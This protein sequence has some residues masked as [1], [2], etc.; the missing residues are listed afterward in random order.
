M[1]VINNSNRRSNCPI[2]CWLDIFGDKWTLLVVRDILF[3]GKKNYRH[4]VSSDEGIATNILASRLAKLVDNGIISK[5]P[6]PNS[7]QIINYEITPMGK[8]LLPLLEHI[9]N[10]S[11]D[12]LSETLTQ[13]EMFEKHGLNS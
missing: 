10:W 9:V 4:F 13:D 2:S 12:T 3:F 5:T 11:N 7:K 1:A 8:E 6:D